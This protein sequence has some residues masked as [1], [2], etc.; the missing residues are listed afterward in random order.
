[1]HVLLCVYVFIMECVCISMH[2]CDNVLYYVWGCV[3]ECVSAWE[4]TCMC[5]DVYIR[6]YVC[7]GVCIL[8][9][10]YVYGCTRVCVCTCGVH[11]QLYTCVMCVC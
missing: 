7:V 1:M 4:Y 8:I 5:G 3:R 6:V 10:I 11:V 2:T 9:Y